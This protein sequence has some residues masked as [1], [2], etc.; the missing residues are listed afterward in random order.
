MGD[1]ATFLCLGIAFESLKLRNMIIELL[2][3]YSTHSQTVKQKQQV[4]DVVP[5]LGKY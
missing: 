5:A 3:L 2:D 1:E 4:P